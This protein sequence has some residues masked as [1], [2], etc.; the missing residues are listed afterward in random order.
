M[1]RIITHPE[2][3][4]NDNFGW[5]YLDTEN[6]LTLPWY[7]IGCLEWLITL[8]IKNLSVFEF[9]CGISSIWWKN[10]CK[11]WEGVDSNTEWSNGSKI[12]S[13][14]VEYTTACIGG[15]YDIIIID[16][17]FR[18]DCTEHALKSIKPGG[19]IIVDNWDQ[20]TV[21]MPASCWKNT[22]ELLK[23]YEMTVHKEPL[24]QD[25]KTA[26]FCIK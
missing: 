23:N 10:E 22:L 24:H 21:D 26:V 17:I 1:K 13:D 12:T 2:N 18:D 14:I 19:Y 9:G 5:R 7:T 6:N 3:G 11:N 15:K 8:D 4:I 25:W 20:E 16:G